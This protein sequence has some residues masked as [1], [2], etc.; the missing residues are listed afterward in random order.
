MRSTLIG[1]LIGIGLVAGTLAPA[2]ACDYQPTSAAND[3]ASPPQ[4]AQAQTA[5]P[6]TSN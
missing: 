2:L 3:H 1:L 4:T 5:A 6:D